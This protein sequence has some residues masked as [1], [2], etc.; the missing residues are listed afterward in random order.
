VKGTLLPHIQQAEWL[1]Q[2]QT[3]YTNLLIESLLEYSKRDEIKA[4]LGLLLKIADVILLHDN[5][6]EDAI[7]LKCY[8]LFHTGRKNQAIQSFNKFTTDYESLLATKPNL[9]FDE[10]VKGL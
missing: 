6:D 3:D 7:K 9:V 5:I 8:A 10:L 4:D 2:Y 1:E